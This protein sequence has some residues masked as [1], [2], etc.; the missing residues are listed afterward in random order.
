MN[1]IS[2]TIAAFALTTPDAAEATALFSLARVLEGHEVPRIDHVATVYNLLTYQA[3]VA[4][5][6]RSLLKMSGCLPDYLPDSGIHRPTFG[7][8]VG[9]ALA[10]LMLSQ[11]QEIRD[12]A[13]LARLNAMLLRAVCSQSPRGA[14]ASAL[15]LRSEPAPMVVIDSDQE[16]RLGV[17][18]VIYLPHV[19]MTYTTMRVDGVDQI[20][21]GIWMLDG[22][23]VEETVATH[24]EALTLLRQWDCWLTHDVLQMAS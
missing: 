9:L 16:T 7:R 13:G 2:R 22:R 6:Q 5:M 24:A 1:S 4:P 14:I 21:V 17:P 19:V 10:D 11:P 8:R 12:Y 18:N 20:Q 3:D 15:T 23:H